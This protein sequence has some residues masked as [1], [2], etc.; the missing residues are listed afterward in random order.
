MRDGILIIVCL[1]LGFSWGFRLKRKKLRN[2]IILLEQ[3]LKEKDE[4]IRNGGKIP[5]TFS[6]DPYVK[7]ESTEP[8]GDSVNETDI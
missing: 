4:I 6:C 3:Q 7:K 5:T 2:Q 1:I 8:T